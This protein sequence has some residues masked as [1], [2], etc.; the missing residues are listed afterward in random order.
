MNDPKTKNYINGILIREKKFDDGNTLL[1][2]SINGAEID[3]L[4]DQLKACIGADGW[5]RFVISKSRNPSFSKKDPS[6]VVSTHYMFEDRR[7][8]TWH[9]QPAQPKPATTNNTDDVPF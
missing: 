1:N 6:R 2:C 9:P 7:D 4:A 5:A 8:T 3:K